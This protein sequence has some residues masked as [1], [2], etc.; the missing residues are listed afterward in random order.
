MVYDMDEN[1]V[2]HFKGKA[3]YNKWVK[4]NPGVEHELDWHE[5]IEP[6]DKAEW[7][8]KNKARQIRD[9]THNA[10]QKWYLTK[11]SSLWRNKDATIQEYKG[12]RKEMRKPVYY[13]D[14]RQFMVDRYRA[15]ILRGMEADDSVAA[16]ARENPGEVVVVSGDKDLRTVA[17][18]HLN[19]S[20]LKDGVEFVSE[21][22]ACR[23]LYS[24][25]LMGDRIDNIK[26]LSGTKGNPGWGVVKAT[27]AMEQFVNEYDM[28]SFV[29]EQY[30]GKYPDG[31][32][33]Y[34]GDHLSWQEIL[35][36]TA[37]LL[38]LRRYRDTKF[39]WED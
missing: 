21:L 14:L 20:K 8:I 9:T 11:G 29:A 12:N 2:G 10:V 24:Q 30:K 32:I 1:L 19:P 7:I 33:G 31:T 6:V 23:F 15:K 16:Q 22:E 28:A 35:C 17:G 13:E 34:E 37:N 5:W 4:K 39:I 25:M 27:K 18:L 26:G 38:F 36:E 3:S